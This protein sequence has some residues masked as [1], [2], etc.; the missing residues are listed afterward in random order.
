M[1][2]Y[3]KKYGGRWDQKQGYTKK[4]NEKKKPYQKK[5]MYYTQKTYKKT[6]RST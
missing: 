5:S 2:Q 3:Q 6:I 1:T 4:Y